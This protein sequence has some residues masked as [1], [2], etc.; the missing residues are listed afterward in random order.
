M[1]KMVISGNVVTPDRAF[2]GAVS[3][4]EGKID[5][6]SEQGALRPDAEWVL[7][8]FIDLHLHGLGDGNVS[9]LEMMRKMAEFGPSTGLTGFLP[10]RSASPLPD[11]L[12]YAEWINELMAHPA[13]TTVLGS[14]LE[15]PF[16]SP[17]RKGGMSLDRLSEPSMEKLEA[18]IA[19]LQGHLRLMT[20]SPEL[21]GT[22]EIIK[23]LVSAGVTAS[24]GH[25]GC[26]PE[27]LKEAADLGI[28]HVCHMFDTFEPRTV[29]G[30]VTQFSLADA[31]LIDDRL[32]IE[33]IVDGVH[34][35]TGLIEVIRR[36]VGKRR[37]VVITDGQR[38][39]GLPEGIYTSV[40][41]GSYRLSFTEGCRRVK[42][43][44][45]IGSCLTMN[46]AFFNLT[47]R[48]GFDPVAAALATSTNAAR[49][50]KLDGV[51]GSLEKG[52]RADIAVLAPDKLTVKLCVIGGSEAYRG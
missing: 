9:S 28:S 43:N 17:A 23:R 1:A 16:I 5:E 37:F 24:A 29:Q 30:G 35:P 50:I 3:V 45:L 11:M 18:L 26:T 33:V 44:G 40:Y 36:V 22:D 4:A 47:T 42:D 21:D 46:R 10:T 14:H 38:G 20:L 51:T 12:N 15:G 2:F 52:K 39:A 32:T 41:G 6:I 13:G 25:T 8:G 34:V 7:P 27:R 49:A 31:A 48:F 19:A